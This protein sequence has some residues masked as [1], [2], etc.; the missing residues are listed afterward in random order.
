MKRRITMSSKRTILIAVI[1]VFLL[2]LSWVPLANAQRFTF[3]TVDVPNALSTFLGGVANNGELAGFY[4]A[5]D[6]STGNIKAHSFV[7]SP[8]G[9]QT[10]PIDCDICPNVVDTVLH[11]I[12]SDGK[13]AAGSWFDSTKQHGLV[14][15][16]A[17][18][19]F[20]QVDFPA[21][22]AQATL[23]NGINKNGEIS[24]G[25]VD[26]NGIEHGFTANLGLGGVTNFMQVDFPGALQT[27]LGDVNDNGD[28][29]GVYLSDK[30]HIVSFLLSGT[31]FT[32]LSSPSGAVVFAR[33]INNLKQI[34]GYVMNSIAFPAAVEGVVNGLPRVSG[35]NRGFFLA[36]PSA[37]AT[38][39]NFPGADAQQTGVGSINDSGMIAGQ[40]NTPGFVTH[41]F[42]AV[43]L[44]P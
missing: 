18:N 11:R 29:V 16:L 30:G 24:G 10:F 43:P 2:P 39:V 1:G 41:G 25:Y 28:L 17:T 38:P 27:E 5:T 21:T 13:T 42:V 15:E 3:T 37:Q 23:L 35:S 6:P 33:G 26:S 32:T 22:G 44:N 7:Q 34:V 40:Y 20:T 14:F 31:T 8:N 4:F 36:S 12:N 19:T 9:I